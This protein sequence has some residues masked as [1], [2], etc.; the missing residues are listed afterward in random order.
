MR[1]AMVLLAALLT[2]ATAAIAAGVREDYA[3]LGAHVDSS[4]IR[5]RTPEGR[6][7]EFVDVLGRKNRCIYRDDGRVGEIRYSTEAGDFAV[8]M[9]YN[10]RGEL[11]SM[12]LADGTIVLFRDGSMRPSTGKASLA[13]NYAAALEHWLSKSN[14]GL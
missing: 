8:L 5:K 10:K 3:L 1:G 11:T 6:V 14:S 13:E 12:R 4:L 9:R 2:I 7:L